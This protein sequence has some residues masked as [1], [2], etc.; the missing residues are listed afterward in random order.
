MVDVQ[1][2]L[3]VKELET[4]KFSMSIDGTK[5]APQGRASHITDGSDAAS[6]QTAVNA[7]LVVL[8]NLGLVAT[9]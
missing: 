6:T 7:V 9:S 8:E 4:I 1:D 5:K 2:T 3:S